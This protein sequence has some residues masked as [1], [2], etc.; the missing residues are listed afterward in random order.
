[1]NKKTTDLIAKTRKEIMQ[2][3]NSIIEDIDKNQ[4]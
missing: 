1:M 2:Q 4:L 3:T